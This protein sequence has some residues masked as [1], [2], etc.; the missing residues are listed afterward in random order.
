MDDRIIVNTADFVIGRS[1]Q[2]LVTLGI[3]SCVAVCLYEKTSK[4]GALLHIMLPIYLEEL[5]G[6]RGQ[7]N[8]LRFADTALGLA[9]V[10]L[11]KLGVVKERLS[12]KLVGGAQMFV[13][14]SKTHDVGAKNVEQTERIL[15]VLGIAIA[16]EEVK[17]TIGRSVEFDLGTGLVK[18]FTKA[19]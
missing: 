12:A 17:G 13:A 1:P 6:G 10:E 2:I 9:V 3:G 19:Q 15:N 16:A 14:F 7:F 8:P 18:I 11:E 5:A 4:I